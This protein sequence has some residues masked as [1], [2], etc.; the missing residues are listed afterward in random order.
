MNWLDLTRNWAESY[1]LLQ[2]RF[3]NLETSAMPFVKLD[4]ARFESYLAAQ[5]GMSLNEARDAFDEFVLNLEE[6]K[7]PMEKRAQT[8]RA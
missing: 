2:A 4:Q 1:K 8:V 7:N 3:P 5:H 6:G